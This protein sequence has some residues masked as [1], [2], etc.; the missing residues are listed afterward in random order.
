[1]GFL[2]G[3]NKLAADLAAGTLAPAKAAAAPSLILGQ[4]ID[5]VLALLFAAILW[6][7]IADML[8]M[9]RR[10]LKGQSV[11]PLSESPH[12]ATQLA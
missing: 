11:Q 6:I 12:V 5:A 4:R 3:A 10:Y 1:V 9:A 2:S 8:R 7:V